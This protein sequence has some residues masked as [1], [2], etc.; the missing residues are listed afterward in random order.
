MNFEPAVTNAHFAPLHRPLFGQIPSQPRRFSSAKS[1]SVTS[2][3]SKAER[4]AGFPPAV[5]RRSFSSGSVPS[6]SPPTLHFPVRRTAGRSLVFCIVCGRIWSIALLI[7]CFATGNLFAC[8]RAIKIFVSAMNTRHQIGPLLSTTFLIVSQASSI[9]W[10]SDLP[11]PMEYVTKFVPRMSVGILSFFPRGATTKTRLRSNAPMNK[12]SSKITLSRGPAC[13]LP[14]QKMTSS[15]ANTITAKCRQ[16]RLILLKITQCELSRARK[17]FPCVH[18]NCLC[19]SIHRLFHPPRRLGCTRFC[20]RADED[21][22]NIISGPDAFQPLAQPISHLFGQTSPKLR[23]FSGDS[24]KV[25]FRDR[26]DNAILFGDDGRTAPLL[27]INYGH[28]SN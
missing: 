19:E 24:C 4:S 9:D 13:R 26:S 23:I 5:P 17:R 1:A 25:R 16:T 14:R 6:V 2:D 22:G 12:P 8:Q 11:T 21:A 27:H 7:F 3:I 20:R 10:S 18:Q 28:L 15:G